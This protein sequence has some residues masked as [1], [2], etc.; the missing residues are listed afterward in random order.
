MIYD[1]KPSV[2]SDRGTIGSAEELDA[3]GVWVKSE[4]Q[5]LVSDLA[6]AAEFSAGAMPYESYDMGFDIP[7]SEPMQ[8][9]AGDFSGSFADDSY[10]G[11][12]YDDGLGAS[13]MGATSPFGSEEISNELLLKIANEL[14]SIR[15]ELNILKKEFADIRAETGAVSHTRDFIDDADEDE[16]TALAHAQ[17]SDF[18]DDVDEDEKITLTGDE[19]ENILSSAS[20]SSEEFPGDELSAN[21]DIDFDPLREADEAALKELSE[22]NESIAY[23]DTAEQ[24]IA[25]QDAAEQELAEQELVEQDTAYQDTA[26][27][28]D[29]TENHEEIDIDFDNL[30]IDL[31]YTEETT[32]P[33]EEVLSLDLGE[34]PQPEETTA[35]EHEFVPLPLEESPEPELSFSVSELEEVTE[36][37]EEDAIS[38]LSEEV[39]SVELLDDTDEMRALRLEG[40]S[41]ITFPPDDSTYLED[42]LSSDIISSITSPDEPTLDDFS[43]DEQA[44]DDNPLDISLDD[45]GF[46]I[47]LDS[48]PEEDAAEEQVSNELQELQ[49]DDSQQEDDLPVDELPAEAME[50][51]SMEETPIDLSSVVIDEPDLSVGIVE[52]PI[53]EPVLE[54]VTLNVDD[55]DLGS[56]FDEEIKEEVPVSNELA[57]DEIVAEDIVLVDDL[58]AS[59]FADN[60]LNVKD[61]DFAVDD[62]GDSIDLDMDDDNLVEADNLVTDDFEASVARD[63]KDEG[64]L[65]PE[66]IPEGFEV[67]A[68]EAAVSLDDDLEVF[69]EEELPRA[70]LEAEE[71]SVKEEVVSAASEPNI[72]SGIQTDL[73]KVLSYMDHL[74][75]S[76]PED[77]IEEFAKSEYFDAY[78]KLFKDLGLA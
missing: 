3:Y 75:E 54:D 39:S 70:E 47:S 29:D 59:D 4:P 34:E 13:A 6:G 71:P 35:I 69:T 32:P 9:D 23:Q 20:L 7:E 12:S 22:Q 31:T 64:L 61:M 27:D 58:A 21:E 15:N 18:F 41:P 57:D 44:L 42:D 65:A 10:S 17:H 52:T 56:T 55:F 30:G 77:K 78:K 53:E 62:L 40:A 68:E 45:S 48:F 28:S 14:S 11:Q 46:D 51:I 73:R 2:Y 67:N 16:K 26:A 50:E 5:D 8:A 19:L 1:K 76:L 36:L 63:I 43:T 25:Y 60:D 66:I 33:E 74:L 49:I 72:P 38:D 24:D 37:T